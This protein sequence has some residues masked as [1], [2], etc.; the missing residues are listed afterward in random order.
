ME[1]LAIA[2]VGIGLI[3]GAVGYLRILLAAF[4]VNAL[5]GVACLAVAGAIPFALMHREEA[6]R[7]LKNFLFGAG[8]WLAGGVVTAMVRGQAN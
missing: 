6:G 5:W 7:P 4:R 1:V 8:I 3:V 2:L